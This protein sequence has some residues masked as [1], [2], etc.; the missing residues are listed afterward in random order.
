MRKLTQSQ[1]SLVD[2][3]QL[4]VK[5]AEELPGLL[6]IMQVGEL[7]KMITD[8]LCPSVGDITALASTCKRAAVC[9]EKSFVSP[10]PWII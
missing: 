1:L 10:F 9:L 7:G 8:K 5:P 2:V 4:K 3:S 6:G